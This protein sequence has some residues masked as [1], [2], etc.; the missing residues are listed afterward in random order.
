[1]SDN[2]PTRIQ[3]TGALDAVFEAPLAVIYKHSPYCG[4]SAWAAKEIHRFMAD[5]PDV[6]VYLVDVVR[7]RS[8]SSELESRLGIRHES[9]QVIVLRDGEARWNASHRGVSAG[10]LA[11]QVTG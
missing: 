1:M 6:P 11:E 5:H 10:A 2:E 4:L 7:D 8:V 9:P 3:E